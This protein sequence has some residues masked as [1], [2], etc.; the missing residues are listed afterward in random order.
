VAATPFIGRLA[1][2]RDLLTHPLS[3]CA[4]HFH[5]IAASNLCGLAPKKEKKTNLNGGAT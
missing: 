5:L 2:S 1:T 4:F 3:G